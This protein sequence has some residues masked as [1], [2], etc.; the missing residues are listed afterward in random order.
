M[1]NRWL[2]SSL[3]I[4]AVKLTLFLSVCCWSEARQEMC[5]TRKTLRTNWILTSSQN[6][7]VKMFK[8]INDVVIYK[9]LSVMRVH[10][11]TWG[12]RLARNGKQAR[13]AWLL[14]SK[15]CGYLTAV[16]AVWLGNSVPMINLLE[17]SG[18]FLSLPVC[19]CAHSIACF[20]CVRCPLVREHWRVSDMKHS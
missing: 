17:Q 5:V 18:S 6:S 14:Q 12:Q 2:G 11:S 16:S 9:T 7:N 15:S 4:G 8:S 13:K 1:P 10:W 20:S 19:R 3:P